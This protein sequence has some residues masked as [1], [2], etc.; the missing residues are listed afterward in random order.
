MQTTEN[1]I[2]PKLAQP[3]SP[4]AILTHVTTQGNSA[5][6]FVATTVTAVQNFGKP[7]ILPTPQIARDSIRSVN[8]AEIQANTV[9]NLGRPVAAPVSSLAVA[10]LTREQL[11]QRPEV[12]IEY[13]YDCDRSYMDSDDK[14]KVTI[15]E[16]F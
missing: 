13:E 6:N 4:A 11:I 1:I 16:M 9:N 14:V 7:R 8:P 15:S 10:T 3:V 2:L 12:S 5:S